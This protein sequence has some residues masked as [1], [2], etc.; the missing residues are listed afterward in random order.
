M[1][2]ILVQLLALYA[3]P[4]AITLTFSLDSTT[5]QKPLVQV[6]SINEQEAALKVP[7]TNNAT[8][9]PTPKASQLFEIEYLEVAPSPIPV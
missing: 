2:S 4:T 9:G 5:H 3:I 8:Y 7:G 6:E 1:K